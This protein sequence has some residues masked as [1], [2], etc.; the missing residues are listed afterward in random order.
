MQP[1]LYRGMTPQ[2][3]GLL[4]V[5]DAVGVNLCILHF[6]SAGRTVSFFYISLLLQSQ[7]VYLTSSGLDS[8]FG[9]NLLEIRLR[10]WLCMLQQCS[11]TR[12]NTNLPAGSLLLFATV[13]MTATASSTSRTGPRRTTRFRTTSTTNV[14]RTRYFHTTTRHFLRTTWCS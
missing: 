14:S 8:R 13:A 9:D 3:P 7:K 6:P 5:A 1:L 11:S 10:Y 4:R 2:Q 12:V